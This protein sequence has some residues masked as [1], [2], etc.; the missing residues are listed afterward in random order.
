MEKIDEAVLASILQDIKSG[1][2]EVFLSSDGKNTVH[3]KN[4]EKIET[5]IKLFDFLK[6]LY[7][8]KQ[9]QAKIE[10]NKPLPNGQKPEGWCDIHN[11]QMK[12]YT[13][14]DRSWYSHF[15]SSDKSW[16]SGK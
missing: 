4:A 1:D 14:N 2:L 6:E 3:V 9:A 12:K 8:T 11:T 15:I 7:G 5:G 10:Y 13:K 16:C